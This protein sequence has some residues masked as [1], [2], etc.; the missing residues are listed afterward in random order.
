MPVVTQPIKSWSKK[1]LKFKHNVYP[2]C[3]DGGDA[4]RFFWVG[5]FCGARSSGKTHTTCQLLKHYER[6]GVVDSQ[7]GKT[8]DQRIILFSPT[9]D[10]N[11]VWS[12]LKHLHADDIHAVYSEDKLKEVVEDI[13]KEHDE[14]ER[15]LQDMAVYEKFMNSKTVNTLTNDEIV[16]LSMNDF[17]APPSPRYPNGCTNFL[18]LDDLVGS[19]ALKNGRS[20]LNYITIRN[21]HMRLCVG[22]LV[23]S[24]KNVPK[25]IR[26]NTNLFAVWRFANRKMVLEDL[27]EEVSSCLT[28]EA[29]EEIY[30]YCTK[31]DHGCMVMDFSAPKE[32]R[33]KKNF[34]EI[35]QLC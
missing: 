32:K 30:D 26:N 33:F 1:P 29:F 12:S 18:I 23:Q 35:V 2:Q 13:Q 4:P 16:Q 3:N 6:H 14:T 8:L 5:L 11:P 25:I 27:Y 15:Y 31:E 19:S 24:M 34:S 17:N 22:I 20:Y 21:R 7:T 9:V 10:A 28:P